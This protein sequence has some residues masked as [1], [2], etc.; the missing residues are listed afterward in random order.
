[1]SFSKLTCYRSII[2][3]FNPNNFKCLFSSNH[4]CNLI[5]LIFT[6]ACSSWQY[7]HL[8]EEAPTPL[9]SLYPSSSGNIYPSFNFLSLT[10]PLLIIC[11]SFLTFIQVAH[12]F[13]L[14]CLFNCKL[15]QIENQFILYLY[16]LNSSYI[17]K[18]DGQH[19]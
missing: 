5:I 17:G 9:S 2:C 16:T 13:T 7:L 4:L 1:M 19:F 12:V 8:Q 6:L 10:H 11:T 14:P 18:I 15:L 3:N